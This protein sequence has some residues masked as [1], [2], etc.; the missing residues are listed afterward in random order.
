MV[1]AVLATF[2]SQ[3][4][5]YRIQSQRNVFAWYA[6]IILY[7]EI[8]ICCSNES[9]EQM[10]YD[11]IADQRNLGTGNYSLILMSSD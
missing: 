7:L 8:A 6:V 5:Q 11:E 10:S 3:F 2:R 9:R 1:P 4:D